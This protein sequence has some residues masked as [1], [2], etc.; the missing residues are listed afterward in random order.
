MKLCTIFALAILILVTLPDPVQSTTTAYLD[1]D[2]TF[3]RERPA[4]SKSILSQ[5]SPWGKKPFP[6][7][8][9]R[10]EGEKGLAVDLVD[11][12]KEISKSK[13]PKSV[14]KSSPLIEIVNNDGVG[15]GFNDPTPVAPV[16]GNSGT[17]LGEQRLIA[18]QYAADIWADLLDITVVVK[19]EA[20]FNPKT[21][22]P[23]SAVLGSAGPVSVRA[24]FSGAPVSNTWYPIA[25]ANQLYGSDLSPGG[26]DITAEFNSSIDNNP[27]CLSGTNWYY[28]IDGSPPGGDID[29]VSVLLHEFCHGLGF[30]TVADAQ[31]GSKLG[32]MDDIFLNQL[33]DE[34]VGKNWNDGTMS[35]GDR[36]ASGIDT[37]DLT[38]TGSEVTT[39]GAGLSNG[40][41]TSGNV[42]MY[43]PN[44]YEEGS[45]VSHFSTSL[46]P[47]AL[48][49]PSYT[50]VN[51]T[52][53]L[54][55]ALMFDIGW[56]PNA[57]GPTA[58]P[59]PTD[60]AILPTATFTSSQTPTSTPTD[61][62]TQTS[63]PTFT[64]TNSPVPP[65]ETP[66]STFTSTHTPTITPSHTA[67]A[68][69]SPTA[70]FTPTNTP[71]PSETHTATSDPT[72][73]PTQI[74]TNTP[75]ETA[76]EFPTETPT[77]EMVDTATPTATETASHT[78]TT[79][80]SADATP[81]STP[82]SAIITMDF[83][84]EPLGE[85]DGIVD[86]ADLIIWYKEVCHGVQEPKILFQ[87]SMHWMENKK[88][89][90]QKLPT[91]P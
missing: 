68:T 30:L 90:K 53:T 82:T 65:T 63:S 10:N 46:F 40:V 2:G 24:S 19:V 25:L 49:E 15:E 5:E 28:G 80:P 74:P 9:M 67:T 62:P 16:G 6:F 47:N 60:T 12:P 59:T 3:L 86:D 50:S 35:N 41:H 79:T 57:A 70:S 29:L 4:K 31:T 14:A 43:A 36:A 87:F 39:L 58:T 21:C 8:K 27:S 72:D 22:S 78:P 84:V 77:Q 89:T 18:F 52:P 81:T 88:E 48:M 61:T 7:M 42:E 37:G 11:R 34:S 26:P 64:A 45:S 1:D 33:R 91:H 38:W 55:A 23:S 76:T 83:D 75:T 54:S 17:T 56:S 32:G 20:E 71:T 51:H 69:H 73:T 66:T 44:P 13:T 85:P